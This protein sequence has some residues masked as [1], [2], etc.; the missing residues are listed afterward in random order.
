LVIQLR[1]KVKFGPSTINFV[2]LV[3]QGL[4]VST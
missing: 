3:S 4:C 2:N 1:D